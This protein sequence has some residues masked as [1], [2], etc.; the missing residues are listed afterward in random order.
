MTQGPDSA[1]WIAGRVFPTLLFGL[2]HPYA[3][4]GDGYTATVGN[5]SVEQ[6]RKFYGEHF[7]PRNSVLIVVGD[8]EPDQVVTLLEEKFSNWKADASAAELPAV[9]QTSVAGTVYMVD[10][11]GAVQS[12]IA[13]GRTWKDRDDESYFATRI[14]NRIFGGD[15]LSRLNQNLRQRN[16]FT[17]GA[18]SAFRFYEHGSN[19]NLT[20]SVRSEVTGAALRE[21]VN[22]LRDA[23]GDRPLTAEE[24]SVARSAEISV[25]PQSFETPASIAGSLA[26]LAIYELPDDYYQELSQAIADDRCCRRRQSD[27]GSRG[28]AADSDPGRRRPKSRRSQVER[29][30]VR[31]H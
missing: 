3:L 16:G 14:G 26:Q 31:P 22:E 12:V 30:W 9:V 2:G 28:S 10:K 8:F 25:F 18:R 29:G 27:G 15:F 19:W 11:P 5:L 23:Q 1:S 24:V 20:T 13:V 7:A 6:V 17:Y 21:I 4:P